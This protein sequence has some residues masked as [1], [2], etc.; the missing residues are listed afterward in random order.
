MT[1]W[2]ENDDFRRAPVAEVIAYWRALVIEHDYWS[3]MTLDDR[4]G[5][6]RRLVSA[7]LRAVLL[8][9]SIESQTDI[10]WS[11]ADHGTFRRRQG[12]DAATVDCDIAIVGG[13][14][15]QFLRREPFRQPERREAR[16]RLK[17]QLRLARH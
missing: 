7:L 5:E 9:M 10:V 1:E 3:T 2:C 4:D 6:L 17:L 14:I 11:A 8:G 16:R 12:A 13:G 15:R